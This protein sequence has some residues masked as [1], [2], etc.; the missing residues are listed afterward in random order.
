MHMR[1][2][3]QKLTIANKYLLRHLLLV[4]STTFVLVISFI[5]SNIILSECAT[6]II[7]IGLS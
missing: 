4:I 3:V 5:L 7:I 6:I 2:T 1:C